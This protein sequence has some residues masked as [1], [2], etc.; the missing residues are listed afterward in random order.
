MPE[1]FDSIPVLI[2]GLEHQPSRVV[3]TGV[4][5][6]FVI[7]V[8]GQVPVGLIGWQA[9][10]AGAASGVEQFRDVE[11]H[12]PKHRVLE[13]EAAGDAEVETVDEYDFGRLSVQLER[14]AMRIVSV[15]AGTFDPQLPGLPQVPPLYRECTLYKHPNFI[16]FETPGMNCTH[17]VPPPVHRLR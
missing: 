13:L 8:D 4:K 9:L 16:P 10:R 2:V 14:G 7:V 3:A 12:A 6:E 5:V 15:A 1:N 17:P 11:M